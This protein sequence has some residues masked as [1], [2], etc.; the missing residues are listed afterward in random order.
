MS[1][2]ISWPVRNNSTSGFSNRSVEFLD[3]LKVQTS[4]QRV[5]LASG[6]FLKAPVVAKTIASLPAYTQSGSGATGVLTADVNGKLPT[7]DGVS[8]LLTDRVLVTSEGSQSNSD[9]GIYVV[10]DLGSGGTP[11]I[12]TRASDA[13]LSDDLKSGTAVFIADG[14]TQKD[15]VYMQ[16][17]SG[18]ITVDKTELVWN[19]FNAVGNLTALNSGAGGV[20]VYNKKNGSVLEFRNINALSSKVTVVLDAGNKEIDIDVNESQMIHNNLFGLTTGDPHSQYTILGGRVG[21][22]TVYGGNSSGNSLVLCS[23]TNGMK[24]SVQFPETTTSTSPTTGAVVVGGGLGVVGT[25]NFGGNM[26]VT[27]NISLTGLVGGI[28]LTLL[29]SQV[30]NLP[31]GLQSLTDG[32]VTQLQNIGVTTISPTQWGYIGSMNQNVSQASNVIFGNVTGTIQ[33]GAQPNIDHNSLMNSGVGDAHTQYAMLAGRV[34]GQTMYGSTSGGQNLYLSSTSH[35]TK[36]QVRVIDATPATGSADGAFNVAGGASVSGNFYIGGDCGVTGN[37]TV[38]GTVNGVDV[39]GLQTD[40]NSF[41]NALQTLTTA[42]VLQLQN[43]DTNVIS[44][45]T[46]TAL[47]LT[48]Q[49][50]GLLKLSATGKVPFVRIETGTSSTTVARGDHTHMWR[51]TEVLNLDTTTTTKSSL[52]SITGNTGNFTIQVY[53][54]SGSGPAATFHICKSA[55][56]GSDG[57]VSRTV[58][59][60]NGAGVELQM[61]WLHTTGCPQIYHENPDVGGGAVQYQVVIRN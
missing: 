36:G 34:S 9:N 52:A 5:T 28:N 4:G 20:G 56:F 53:S 54:N 50:N 35:A 23:T 16:S 29:N 17:T 13:N 6:P 27:G 10:T 11:W 42:E 12:F 2:P 61:E 7:I 41:P 59:Q 48:D 33:T 19:Q 51:M 47:G 49:N 22:Q 32:E 18:N 40:V 21:G 26:T 39:V 38:T 25:S 14:I 3:N 24:G 60:P 43:I 55:G 31:S 1:E 57:A 15:S 30:S 46:W 44:S 37:M 8:L 45:A 58:S